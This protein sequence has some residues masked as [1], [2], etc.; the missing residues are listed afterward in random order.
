[1]K[2]Q[3]QFDYILANLIGISVSR[4]VSGD[5]EFPSIEKV[6]PTLF[7]DNDAAVKAKQ[8]QKEAEKAMEASTN[9]FLE[10]ALKHNQ[11][12]KENKEV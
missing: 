1:M 12:M 10:F 7:D 3:A 4:V 11:R 2:S 8:E 6:Y 9:R 5:T